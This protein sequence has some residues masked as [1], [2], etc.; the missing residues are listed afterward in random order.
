MIANGEE[1]KGGGQ[2]GRTMLVDGDAGGSSFLVTSESA[3]R[4]YCSNS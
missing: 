4:A 3:N 2:M 1:D